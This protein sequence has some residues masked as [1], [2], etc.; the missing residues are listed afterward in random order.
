MNRLEWIEVEYGDV[1]GVRA[2]SKLFTQYD[3]EILQ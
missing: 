2:N 1:C 3:S